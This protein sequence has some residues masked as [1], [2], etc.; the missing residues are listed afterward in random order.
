MI[1]NCEILQNLYIKY[2][3]RAVLSCLF[4]EPNALLWWLNPDSKDIE[5]LQR[6]IVKA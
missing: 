3:E 6:N 2:Q 4:S 5:K 1:V